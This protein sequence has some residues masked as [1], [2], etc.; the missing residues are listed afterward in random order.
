MIY[1]TLYHPLEPIFSAQN[2]LL[3]VMASH[4]THIIEMALL[5]LT[6]A[7]LKWWQPPRRWERTPCEVK[8]FNKSTTFH[9]SELYQV[10]KFGAHALLYLTQSVFFMFVYLLKLQQ[11]KR[12]ILIEGCDLTRCSSLYMFFKIA[13]FSSLMC[14]SLLPY[15]CDLPYVLY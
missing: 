12:C 3:E 5:T 10:Q 2:P 7:E 13:F 11:A 1:S 9:S 14:F 6:H 4:V 15:V 8:A